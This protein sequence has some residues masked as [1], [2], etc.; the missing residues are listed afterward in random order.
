M[1][2]VKRHR[3]L[4]LIVPLGVV[5]IAT[6]NVYLN[7]QE[8]PALAV[9]ALVAG[10][11]L[12]VV[13]T[14][15]AD[16]P[17]MEHP[18]SPSNAGSIPT[19]RWWA[20]AV[21]IAA[22]GA[23]WMWSSDNTFRTPGV[24]CWMIAII[25]WMVAWWPGVPDVR[26]LE[27]ELHRRT[28]LPVRDLL[29]ILSLI[30]VVAIAAWFRF[31]RIDGVPLDPTSDH[32]EKLFDVTDVLN[33]KRPI[34]FERNTGREPLQFYLTAGL[35]RI[36]DLPVS[37][38]TLK[39]GTALIGTLAIPF[40]YLFGS[41]L[42]GR[43]A[44][45]F[46]AILAAIG[47]WPVEISRAGLRFPYAMLAA[48]AVLWLLLR[49]MRTRDRRDALWC[50]LAIGVGLYGYTPFRVVVLAVCLG[51][52][53]ALVSARGWAMRRLVI[54]D[55]L[56]IGLTAGIVFVPL[57]RYAIEHP[58]MFWYRAGGRLTGEQGEGNAFGAFVDK[59]PIF[60]ENNWNAA[61]GFNWRGDSTYVNAVTFAPMMDVV[62]GALLLAGFAIIVAH[63]GRR[64]DVR[65][66]F[67]LLAIPILLLSSTL[68]VAFPL[69]NPSVNRAAPA[70]PVM[71]AVAGIP[72]AVAVRRC[73]AAIGTVRGGAV[74]FALT[75]IALVIATGRNIDTYFHDFNWQTRL[76]VDNTTEIARVIDGAAAV[77][78]APG[79]AYIIDWP[80]WLD[81]RNIGIALGDISWGTAHVVGTDEPLPP[82]APDRPLLFVL[83]YED[84]ERLAEV[85]RTYP[86]S[87]AT[88]YPAK[89]PT[90]SFVTVWVP[91]AHPPLSAIGPSLPVRT[92][93]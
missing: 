3:A 20:L 60:L 88:A 90:Q 80:H 5:L 53:C 73:Q 2:D 21:S 70:V 11:G 55:G 83:Y 48:A 46:A 74:A 18:Q 66:M 68:A 26:W 28:Q 93:W 39:A 33:G 37:F 40:I 89:V 13:D 77:G 36:F 31:H 65:A 91:A 34:F 67:V 45:V 85:L 32:A 87:F 84:T 86:G 54:A 10:V 78:I 14:W 47:T 75:S 38:T 71:F 9:V 51:I 56:L 61:L 8:L 1:R 19:I 72:L 58:D 92:S 30:A 6:A 4:F 12:L 41:E 49:W 81:A 42:A 25:A 76:A 64:R 43:M 62:T 79:D 7:R 82:Q 52:V 50:G 22:V 35:I 15:R 69:E 29:L 59:L 17:V 44:G 63:V 16:T 27:R 23:T 57:G 24:A